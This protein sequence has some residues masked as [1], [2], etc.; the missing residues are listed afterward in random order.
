[1]ITQEFGTGKFILNFALLYRR[2]LH[3]QKFVFSKVISLNFRK[4]KRSSI[5]I[6][7][8]LEESV[9]FSFLYRRMMEFRKTDISKKIFI[10]K[11]ILFAFTV[12]FLYAGNYEW[13]GTVSDDTNIAAPSTIILTADAEFTGEVKLYKKDWITIDLQGH[14]LTINKLHIGNDSTETGWVSFIDSTGGGSVEIDT[15]SSTTYALDKKKLEI[16]SGVTVSVNNQWNSGNNIFNGGIQLSG[17]GTFNINCSIDDTSK[18]SV[19]SSNTPVISGTNTAAITS[20][21]GAPPSTDYTWTGTTNSDWENSGNWLDGIIP[22]SGTAYP[23]YIPKECIHYP[24]TSTPLAIDT[25]IIE[26]GAEFS[27]DSPIEITNLNA[28]GEI[29]FNRDAQIGTLNLI[30]D[31]TINTSGNITVTGDIEDQGSDDSLTISCSNFYAGGSIGQTS[32][33]K[34]ISITGHFEGTSGSEHPV[35]ISGKLTIDGNDACLRGNINADSVEIKKPCSILGATNAITTTGTQSYNGIKINSDTGLLTLEG[36]TVTLNGDINTHESAGPAKSLKIIGDVLSGTTLNIGGTKPLN[37]FTVTGTSSLRGT[38]TT[39]GLQTYTGPVTLSADTTILTDSASVIFGD[40]V[41]GGTHNLTIGSATDTTQSEFNGNVTGVSTLNLYGDSTLGAN[42]NVAVWNN[43]SDRTITP[44]TSTVTVSSKV[45]GSNT[46]N[47]LTISSTTGS[48][49][50]EAGKTQTISGTFTAAGSAS[51]EISLLSTTS[52]TQWKLNA[53]SASISYAKLKDA[54]NISGTSIAPSNS[55]NLGNNTGFDL[56]SKFRWNASA[57]D[58]DVTQLSNWELNTEGTTWITAT[59][60]PGESSQNDEVEIQ[61]STNNPDFTST[62][63]I[64]CKTLTIDSGAE[65]TLSNAGNIQVKDASF[66][67]EGKIIFSN[68]GRITDS[69]ASGTATP[70]MDSTQGT[71]EYTGDADEVTNY[72]ASGD[73]DY[74]DLIISADISLS[75]EHMT[76]IKNTLTLKT[77]YKITNGY[78]LYV[79]GTSSIGGDITTQRDQNFQKAVTFTT[80]SAKLLTTNQATGSSGYPYRAYFNKG[81]AGITSGTALTFNDVGFA[82]DTTMTNIST[83]TVNEITNNA[84]TITTSGLQTY[85][86]AVTNTGTINVANTGNDTTA[87]IFADGYNGTGGTITGNSVANPVVEIQGGDVKLGTFNHN[88]DKLL[89]STGTSNITD[90]LTCYNLEIAS[91]AAV[92]GGSSTI[93]VQNDWTN[94]GTFTPGTSTVKVAGN[95]SGDNSFYNLTIDGAANSTSQI[96][97]SNTIRT[98]SC[99]TDNKTIS[100]TA[101]T[102][103]TVTSKLDIS[104]SATKEIILT[105]AGV[106]NIDVSSISAEADK[107]VANVKVKNSTADSTKIIA[108]ASLSLGGNTNWII[109]QDFV[110]AGTTDTDWKTSSNW[111]ITFNGAETTANQYPGE[112]SDADTVTFDSRIASNEPSYTNTITSAIKIKSL[113]IDGTSRVL[114]FS[115]TSDI[116]VTDG[117]IINNGTIVYSNTGR[118][119][120]NTAT[121][122]V[123]MDAENGTVEFTTTASTI[124]NI[125]TGNDYNNLILSGTLTLLDDIKTNGT[126]VLRNDVTITGSGKKLTI[127]STTDSIDST[128]KNLTLGATGAPVNFEFKNIGNNYKLNNITAFGTFTANPATISIT[129]ALDCKS[130]ATFRG[131]INAASVNVDGTLIFG[132]ATRKVTTTGTAGQTYNGPVQINTDASDNDNTLTLLAGTN[133]VNFN[134]TIDKYTTG[135]PV[136]ELIIGDTSNLTNVKFNG[137]ISQLTSLS[138]KGTTEFTSNISSV[139]T[140]GNQSYT[141]NVS[142][143]SNFTMST[144]TTAV[145]SIENDLTGSTNAL[146]LSSGTMKFKTGKFETG[147]F[148]VNTGATFTQTGDN[149]TNLQSVAKIVNDGTMTWDSA[150][151][152]GTITIGSDGITQADGSHLVNFNKKNVTLTT[153]SVSGIFYNL[154]IPNGVALTNNLAIVVRN[155]LTVDGSG[156]YIHNNKDLYLG[157]YSFGGTTYASNPAAGTTGTIT[158]SNSPA[159]PATINFGKTTINPGASYKVFEIPAQFVSLSS[160]D[161]T[162]GG[163]ITFKKDITVNNNSTLSTKAQID[164]AA[165]DPAS[166]VTQFTSGVSISNSTKITLGGTFKSTATASAAISIASPVE[167]TSNTIFSSNGQNISFGSTISNA[168]GTSNEFS[169]TTTNT[170][171]TIEF[172]G[173][174]SVK[175]FTVTEGK[176]NLGGA[177]AVT[178]TTANDDILFNGNATNTKVTLYQPVTFTTGTGAGNITLNQPIDASSTAA[179]QSL[180]LSSGTGKIFLN[181]TIGNTQPIGSLTATGLTQINATVKTNNKPITFNSTTYLACKNT[182]DANTT[183]LSSGTS[184]ITVANSSSDLYIS[185]L[186]ADNNA[187]NITITAG[188]LSV[189]GNIAL[190]NGNVTLK[191]NMTSGKDIILLNGSDSSMYKLESETNHIAYINSMRTSANKLKEPSLTAFPTTMPDATTTIGHTVYKSS[192]SDFNG[193]TIKAGQNFYDNGVNLSP[194]AGWTLSLKANNDATVSFAEAYNAHIGFC[195]VTAHDGTF[196]WLSAGEGCTN[197]GNNAT[198]EDDQIDYGTDNGTGAVTC[199]LTGIAFL[200]PV[201]L[202]A[203]TTKSAAEG[204]T[205]GPEIP[206]LSGTYAVRDNVIRIEFVRNNYIP[207]RNQKS[208]TALIENSNNEISAAASRFKFNDGQTAFIGTYIDAECTVSTDGKGDLAVF[209]IKANSK[210]NLDAS[211]TT[212]GT[213]PDTDGV[214]H[215]DVYND[216]EFTK[217]ISGVFAS[218]YDNHKNRIADYSQ[219][220][221]ARPTPDSREGH[222]FTAVISRYV[223]DAM[224]I[225]FTVA[226]FTTKKL[227]IYFNDALDNDNITWG[228]S[229]IATEDSIKFYSDTTT[230]APSIT[231]E[232]IELNALND[233]GIVL[234]LNNLDYSMIQY[235]IKI[236]YSSSYF[237]NNKIHG[238]HNLVV[239]NGESHCITDVITNCVEVQYAY[240]NRNDTYIDST[241]GLAPEDSIVMRD[242]T[243]TG[244]HNKVFAD[245]NITLVTKDIAPEDSAG[246][247]ADFKY[248]LV[249]DITPSAKCD[250]TT[251]EENSGHKTRFWFAEGTTAIDGFSPVLNSS[252]NKRNS[253]SNPDLI[254]QTV[255]TD[256]IVYY[257]HNFSEESPCLNWPSGSDVRFLF[258]VLDG[259]G[260]PITINHSFDGATYEEGT[261]RSPLYCARLINPLDPTSIDLWSFLISEPYRQRGGVSIYSNV[262]NATNK[263]FCTLE[264]NMP[265][266]GNLRVIVMTADG[267]IVK[268]LEN[269]RQSTGLHYYYW[270]GTNNAGDTVARGI[271]FVRVVGPEI[272]ETRKVMVVK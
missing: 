26:T 192:L 183:T 61:P 32:P 146:T 134:S 20:I 257:F 82:S 12:N 27:S 63:D 202:V 197:D 57:S 198:D 72:G 50:F 35:T 129:G 87:V 188:T 109:A 107:T 267:N 85:T 19:D 89:F 231:I 36:T 133:T 259:T 194:S 108:S 177:S 56:P 64:I 254:T 153:S 13:S 55:I 195:T 75:T 2:K 228:G 90:N 127:G 132:H 112:L 139:S 245:K 173:N 226:D 240:D 193:K 251:Y 208:A 46:F 11:I 242:F 59:S 255:N 100:F 155:N 79:E 77:G 8:V 199:N 149:G 158:R 53:S 244:K 73:Y 83:L 23:I 116:F 220:P 29:N 15:L 74:Y 118:I 144:G 159:T 239:N 232:N 237:L 161:S 222:R 86:G 22:P 43:P 125:S 94:N 243:G 42:I 103:Q 81:I 234:T 236:E 65:L 128:A 209:Y 191:A 156:S 166:R 235:G 203:D 162:A 263:D 93:T 39:T 37:E 1:M 204:R 141:G 119:K 171:G 176:V 69:P 24:Q 272:E 124:D 140:T 111:K 71:V 269:G 170:S 145:I 40:T 84:G 135:S 92:T 30:G 187:K 154:T 200:H 219:T 213:T 130:S 78:S 201:F 47:N 184:N 189:S 66:T 175:K 44:G 253:V 169:I 223:I 4:L 196:A 49:Q 227:Y 38:I 210:W 157:S 148:T 28:G 206:N 115:N 225:S 62:S 205:T 68:T 48:V 104:S 216:I 164:F 7:L 247:P 45:N 96:T 241:G 91:G 126:L 110:W 34:D 9:L 138:V 160:T 181:N 51:N 123:I 113:T 271:Y 186:K 258:E 262:I 3:G 207:G 212:V 17:S 60:L 260:Q 99:H 147:T 190:F 233:H 224:H 70:I 270:N 52:G 268:Y 10:L 264:V 246:N 25:L 248:K 172:K 97:D 250:G 151:D 136:P 217:I 18:I 16:D 168:T 98:L 266:D 252:T 54:N 215:T 185:A 14:N 265:K 137:N 131:N 221:Y 21:T 150:S 174:V 261:Q 179:T 102:T 167:L 106:W 101:G 180:T 122:V 249:A 182:A 211:G 80:S 229:P 95:V 117:T 31:L 163:K 58:S 152:G 142:F 238:K 214:L 114:T 120:N 33:I 165:D 41:T 105:S 256:N 178:I 5:F 121:P 88:G 143:A 6:L 218:L 230:Q 67:N 76:K